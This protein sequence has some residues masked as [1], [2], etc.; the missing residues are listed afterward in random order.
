TLVANGN[1]VSDHELSERLG[2]SLTQLSAWRRRL[3]GL[4]LITWLVNPAGGC[5]YQVNAVNRL[6][7]SL[8]ATEPTFAARPLTPAVPASAIW[9][10]V[11]EKSIALSGKLIEDL[12]ASEVA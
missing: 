10:A 7:E 11:Q 1:V 9:R 12:D 3:Y 6:L 4:G 2:I 8:K 5:I